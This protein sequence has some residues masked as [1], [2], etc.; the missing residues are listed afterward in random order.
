M[1]ERYYLH[2]LNSFPQFGPQRLS[3]LINY[4]PNYEAAFAASTQELGEAGIET[5]LINHWLSYKTSLNLEQEINF[6]HKFDIIISFEVLEHLKKEAIP[7]I[8]KTIANHMGTDSIFLGTASTREMDVH[9]T[10]ENKEWWLNEFN[11]VGLI[12]HPDSGEI[13]EKMSNNHPYNWNIATSILF[14]MKKK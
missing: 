3:R 7:N 10:V 13:L 9:F 5:N 2:L 6:N 4:F 11:K 14:A 8:M 12:P 1:L